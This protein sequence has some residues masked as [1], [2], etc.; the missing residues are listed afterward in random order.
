M[1]TNDAQCLGCAYGR[2]PRQVP[3]RVSRGPFARRQEA[4]FGAHEAKAGQPARS[5]TTAG[6]GVWTD[7]AV[8]AEHGDV[9]GDRSGSAALVPVVEASDFGQ[10]HDV[11]QVT[12]DSAI[13][14]MSC[15]TSAETSPFDGVRERDFHFQSRRKPARCQRTTVSG[16]TMTRASDQRD[17]IWDRPTQKARSAR[18]R[19]TQGV[20]RCSAVSCWR[21]AR[22]SRA[23]SARV[24]KADRTLASRLRSRASMATRRMM[25]SNQNLPC[26]VTSSPTVNWCLG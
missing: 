15:L 3:V 21:R 19:R 16:L 5:E 18:R 23:R 9:T 6:I 26:Q 8:R 1:Q 14:R 4:C 10:L 20:R 25:A 13:R 17:Q 11:P 12:L 22:F 7:L 2:V 24:R